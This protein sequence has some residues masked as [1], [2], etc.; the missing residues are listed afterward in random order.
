MFIGVLIV[1]FMANV[2]R[3]GNGFI[4]IKEFI[5][6]SA[7]LLMFTIHFKTHK[8]T[9]ILLVISTGIVALPGLSS[10]AALD[11]SAVFRSGSIVSESSFGL[12]APLVGILFYTQ[13]RYALFAVTL[14][15]SLLLF[16]RIAIGAVIVV[17]LFDM[18]FHM[19]GRNLIAKSGIYRLCTGLLLG[20]A[21][22]FC[23]NS[24]VAYEMVSIILQKYLDVFVPPNEISSG[25]YF[26]T[27]YFSDTISQQSSIITFLMGHGPGKSTFTLATLPELAE[28][29]FPLLHNDFLRIS[30]DY[31]AVGVLLVVYALW[32]S[33]QGGRLVALTAL[34]TVFMF[35]TDNVATYLLYWLALAFVLRCESVAQPQTAVQPMVNSD[36]STQAYAQ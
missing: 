36:A 10:L 25:R 7:S 11:T 14:L 13:R 22:V 18:A 24:V 4:A 34:Y 35:M 12:V 5:F 9:A 19:G 31:G 23:L 21:L 16:K 6:I 3:L 15:I 1:F 8:I 33:L 26:A 28:T 20:G 27:L 2:L 17:I 30:V 32:R 29:N